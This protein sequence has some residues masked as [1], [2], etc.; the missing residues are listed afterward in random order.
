[1]NTDKMKVLLVDDEPLARRRVRNLLR[2]HDDVEVIGEATDGRAAVAEIRARKP[3]V[4]L[5][6]VQMPE[7]DGFGVIEEIGTKDL[8]AVI[9]VTAYDKYALAAFEVCALDYLLK[10]FDEERFDKAL[11]RARLQ[12]RKGK[13]HEGGDDIDR[14]L[15]MLI[16]QM[17]GEKKYLDRLMVKSNGRMFF[18]RATDIDWIEA[19]G[20]YARLHVAKEDHLIRET[21]NELEERLDPE[22]FLR[23]HRSTLVNIDR[24]KE[25]HPWFSGDYAVILQDG[26]QLRLSRGQREKLQS[27]LGKVL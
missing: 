27:R 24:I 4:V 16:E 14:K 26:T 23:I 12:K 15:R 20:N 1:M 11:D 25:M 22:R 5:L 6:D 21:M 7:L 13:T 10:P 9:F 3:D 17:N 19:E 18:V 2:R 8:P